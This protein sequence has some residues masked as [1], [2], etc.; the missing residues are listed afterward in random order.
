MNKKTKIALINTY[1]KERST[2]STCFDIVQSFNNDLF[3]C[4]C[5]YFV[6]DKNYE[7]TFFF[8]KK[9]EKI[10]HSIC[11]HSIGLEGYASIST[12]KN[13]TDYLSSYQPDIVHLFVLHSHILNLKMLFDSLN[14]LNCKVFV[15]LDDCWWF[16][17][18]CMYPIKHECTKFITQCN[19]CPAQHDSPNSYFF[20]FS[21]KMQRDKY[22]YFYNIDS[23][24]A[25][26]VSNWVKTQAETSFIFKEKKVHLLNNWIDESIFCSNN[27]INNFS[28]KLLFVS[29]MWPKD[30]TKYRY[31]LQLHSLL[32]DDFAFTVVGDTCGN[33]LNNMKVL[34][35]VND[36]NELAQIY[37]SHDIYVHLSEFDTF[38][39]VVME[40]IF[41]GTPV[42]AFNNTVMKEVIENCGVVA[43]NKD[44]RDLARQIKAVA[45]NLSLYRENIMKR[46]L[47]C[48]TKKSAMALLEKIYM[49]G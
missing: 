31:L 23:V 13:L 15:H 33:K 35:V 44:I 1:Y 34:G 46:D 3:E 8:G 26:A 6:N 20:D 18:K 40:A 25:I 24:S 48:Y 38:G 12:T 7:S 36:P 27:K 22:D 41:C 11:S 9:Y 5:C 2:G 17:G 28:N 29:S 16:T 21:K 37:R 4:R 42:V 47:S 30:S 32:K 49:E 14:Q 10:F 43:I 39:K 45:T 19:Q